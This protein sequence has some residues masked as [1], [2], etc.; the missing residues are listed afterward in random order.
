[1]G[2][3]SDEHKDF[4]E[5]PSHYQ[6]HSQNHGPVEMDVGQQLHELKVDEQVH[7]LKAR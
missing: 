1:M 4:Q 7:E 2:P 5:Q 3:C 6:H